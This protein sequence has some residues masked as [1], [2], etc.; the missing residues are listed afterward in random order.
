[1]ESESRAIEHY[2]FDLLQKLPI[3]YVALMSGFWLMYIF[4]S[5]QLE[6]CYI[7]FM[8]LFTLQTVWLQMGLM[9]WVLI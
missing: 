5:P 9:G 2:I 8:L 4:L 6:S 1:M 7:F 3:F